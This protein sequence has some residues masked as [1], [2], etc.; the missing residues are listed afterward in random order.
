M[1]LLRTRIFRHYACGLIC[2]FLGAWLT[3]MTG[4]M[5][6]LALGAAA[7]V[8]STAPLVRTIWSKKTARGDTR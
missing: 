6:P 5:L 2:T 7:S 3:A 4:S 8:M 1:S